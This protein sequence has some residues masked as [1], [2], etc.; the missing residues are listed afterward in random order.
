MLRRRAPAGA[1]HVSDGPGRLTQAL[2]IRVHHNG[3]PL[4]RRQRRSGHRSGRVNDRIWIDDRGT[5][6]AAADTICS[7]RVGI[8]Y[9][10]PDARL[11]WRFGVSPS[12]LQQW[13]D[14]AKTGK[15]RA[16]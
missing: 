7:P 14:L 5:G 15:G 9:A 3:T 2:G 4:T 8:D 6:V 10:G 11:P 16:L 1:S 12:W 13:S